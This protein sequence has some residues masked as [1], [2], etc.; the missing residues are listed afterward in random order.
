MS[1]IVIRGGS[2][3]LGRALTARLVDR[4]DEVVILSCTDTRPIDGARTV[5]WD[6]ESVGTWATELD[7]ADS[8]VHLNGRRVD[9]RATK[10]HID[11]LISSRVQ[12]GDGGNALI[13]EHSTPTGIG[14]REMVTVCLAWEAA[15]HHASATVD[16]TVL[17]R[18]GIGLGGRDDPG[19]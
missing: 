10:K 18:M 5:A 12:P 3:H 16:R 19:S 17:L 13:D 14:P 15:F 2:G 11:E 1:R 8:I 7:G 9:V 4:G 6:A